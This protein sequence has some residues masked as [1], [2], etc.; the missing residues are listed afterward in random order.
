MA[1]RACMCLKR[2][3]KSGRFCSCAKGSRQLPMAGLNHGCHAI[4]SAY[5]HRSS[6]SSAYSCCP[7]ALQKK[8]KK[9]NLQY[10]VGLPVQQIQLRRVFQCSTYQRMVITRGIFCDGAC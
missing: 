3:E 10:S 4:S 9:F 2:A 8:K 1:A 5:K 6:I 7:V